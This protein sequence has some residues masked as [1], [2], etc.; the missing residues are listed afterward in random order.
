MNYSFA[1]C[2]PIIQ[3]YIML[4]SEPSKRLYC[5]L[6]LKASKI[7]LKLLSNV[8][9][10]VYTVILNSRFNSDLLLRKGKELAMTI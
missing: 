8:N 4:E 5:T 9:I 7:Y 10:F 3:N 6:N 1:L 2:H